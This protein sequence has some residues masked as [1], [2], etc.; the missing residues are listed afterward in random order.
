MSNFID[1]LR[2]VSLIEFAWH[3]HL[4]WRKNQT[5]KYEIPIGRISE[6]RVISDR[7]TLSTLKY[8]S[9]E[10]S[11]HSYQHLLSQNIS[12]IC[13]NP[14]FH[15]LPFL[16]HYTTS[17]QMPWWEYEKLRW[18][19]SL[20]AYLLS[21]LGYGSFEHS[22]LLYF[23]LKYVKIFQ[24]FWIK[25]FAVIT[26]LVWKGTDEFRRVPY[27]HY[28][29][30]VTYLLWMVLYF[31]KNKLFYCVDKVIVNKISNTFCMYYCKHEYMYW[32]GVWWYTRMQT[33]TN[34]LVK[35]L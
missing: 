24:F 35:K 2:P 33:T 30:I 15:F 34:K 4:E 26:F 10:H 11:F 9:F 21:S 5:R 6:L 18:T 3:I 28:S 32:L 14:R 13:Y 20:V 23:S 25:P 8:D 1:A 29:I 7:C 17:F 16:L 19:S 22:Y 27:L 31:K 12:S